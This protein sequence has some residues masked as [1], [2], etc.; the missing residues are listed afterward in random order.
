MEICA[1]PY[2]LLH[3]IRQFIK[4]YYATIIQAQLQF[5]LLNFFLV[6]VS[7]HLKNIFFYVT[8]TEH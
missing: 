2:G 8:V 3:E 6:A 4:I 7:I 1:S 5:A